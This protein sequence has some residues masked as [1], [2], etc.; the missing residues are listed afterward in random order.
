MSFK[1][2]FLKNTARFGGYTYFIQLI[3]FAS[4]I[5]LSRIISPE[6]YGFVALITVFSGF[7]FVFTQVGVLHAIIRND[8]DEKKLGD[9]FSLTL[10]I[11][12]LLFLIFS[13]LAYPIALFYDDMRLVLPSLVVGL[14]FI[15]QSINYVPSAI[16]SKHLRFN[17]IGEARILQTVVQVVAMI[18]LAVLGFSYWSLIIPITFSPI[19]QYIYYYY[20][21][22]FQRKYLGIRSAWLLLIEI[23]SLVGSITLSSIINYWT[24]NADNLAIGKIYGDAALGNY[25]RAYRFIFLAKRLINSIFGT[26][27]FPSLKKLKENN[28]DV[29]KEF[30]AILGI[31]SIA[32]FP[33]GIVLILFA[34]PL[35]LILWGSDWTGV[36]KF[37]PYIGVL[38]L[39]QTVFAAT[40]DFYVLQKKERTILNITMINSI[41]SVAAIIT[42]AFFSPL[43]IIFLVTVAN[44]IMIPIQVYIGFYKA[45]Q[46]KVKELLLFWGPKFVISGFFIY[47]IYYELYLYQV[48]TT[49]VY[50]IHLVTMQKRD[51]INFWNMAVKKV[52][53]N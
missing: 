38:I 34:E 33:M 10:W 45:L 30:L 40:R 14:T 2:D 4:T 13:L 19:V 20:R 22:D 51:I 37:L 11:G 31:I 32:N 8:Y 42:G 44:T 9:F 7:V 27:L 47:T 43:H 3:E 52:R 41:M 26:V 21:I 48:V 12:V 39:V 53:G 18:V 46:F 36:I 15:T 50:T 35:V 1:K 29:N 6:E 24:N 16:A 17:L 5:I 23:K 28:G 25:N 49:I